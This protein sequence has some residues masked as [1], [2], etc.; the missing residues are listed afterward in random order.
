MDPLLTP[1]NTARPVTLAVDIGGS[2]L[3][4][5]LLDPSGKVIDGPVRVDTPDKATPSAVLAGLRSLTLELGAFDRISVGFPGVVRYGR[6]LNAPNLD[7]DGWRNF[8][9]ATAL[10]ER[11]DRPARVMNDAEVQGLGVIAF[12]GVECVVTLGT[13]MGFA[14]FQDGHP[15]P[16]LELAHHPLRKGRTYEEYVGRRALDDVGAKKWN[17]RV[18][19][20]I[21]SI[22][23]LVSYDTLYIGGGN[24]RHLVPDFPTNVHI[25]DNEA[26]MTGGIHL[27]D[28]EMD[29]LFAIV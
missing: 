21:A 3:K 24:A 15:G 23:R 11:F 27:W 17:R 20:A 16:H 7:N 5:L 19:R 6:V 8:S 14:V 26:G 18:R 28:S 2:H 22:E 9:L 25:V 13:G 4:A 12:R 1:G 29:P 10:R